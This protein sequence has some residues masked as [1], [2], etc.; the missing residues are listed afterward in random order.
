MTMQERVQQLLDYTGVKLNGS[1]PWDIQVHDERLYRR[2]LTQG[3]LG[4]G[5]AYMDG[6]WDC[7][8]IDELVTRLL[9]DDIRTHMR[10][11]WPQMAIL[12][13]SILI[14]RQSSGRAF[15]I[16]EAHYDAGNDL[17]RAMLDDLY[18]WL[19][20]GRKNAQR[21][22]GSQARSDLSQDWAQGG[23]SCA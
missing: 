6:W 20:E 1:N 7:E 3:S 13:A 17:Y 5:E 21:G 15:K 19:L 16:G 11:R 22:A 8:R 10:K 2:V 9:K 4:L 23:R 12:L 14:N 18:L